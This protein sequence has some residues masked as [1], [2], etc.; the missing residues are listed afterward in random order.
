MP[1]DEVVATPQAATNGPPTAAPQAAEPSAAASGAATTDEGKPKLSASE[2]AAIARAKAEGREWKRKFNESSQQWESRLRAESEARQAT[3]TKL[4]Q[5]QRQIEAIQQA[6][7]AHV[8]DPDRA[9][10]DFVQG[11][12][13]EKKTAK[14]I[15]EARRI[16]EETQKKLDDKIKEFDELSKK[17]QEERAEQARQGAVQGFVRAV[18]QGEAAKKYAHLNAVHSAKE[19]AAMA[20][21]IQRWAESDGKAFTFEQ[22]AQHLE[23]RSKA[24]YDERKERLLELAG[25]NPAAGLVPPPQTGRGEASAGSGHRQSGP[26]PGAKPLMGAALRAHER[27]LREQEEAEDVANLR[28]ATAAD[29]AAKARD[30]KA[31]AKAR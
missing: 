15:A 30:A 20:M 1:P 26:A 31:A 11:D 29:S 5:L 24:V 14:E 22:V 9:I 8:A 2:H 6:P 17:Q 28:K 23:N 3:E 27:K 13:P 4:A 12:T 25:V 10:R 18:T 21:E 19:I 16:A 7:L